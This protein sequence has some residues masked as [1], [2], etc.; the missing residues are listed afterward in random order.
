LD[1]HSRRIGV[2]RQ[3][4][5]IVTNPNPKFFSS[6]VFGVRAISRSWHQTGL[7][8]AQAA[9]YL[10]K[11]ARG[12]QDKDEKMR[13]LEAIKMR[14]GTDSNIANW[15]KKVTEA[16]ASMKL[17]IR[18]MEAKW[19]NL[20]KILWLDQNI[21]PAN[22]GETPDIEDEFC[23]A[24]KKALSK[25]KVPQIDGGNDDDENASSPVQAIPQADGGNDEGEN[26]SPPAPAKFSSP[27]A[28]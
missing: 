12:V 15:N 3:F 25:K 2:A 22:A 17:Y 21:L 26:P 1:I 10:G 8:A 18:N 11:F 9:N 24:L 23:K 19:P 13:W 14:F 28:S 5:V 16:L 20:A 27:P 7:D 6:E 4:G